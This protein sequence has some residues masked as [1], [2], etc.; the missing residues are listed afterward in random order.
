MKMEKK[1]LNMHFILVMKQR[2]FRFEV[3][4]ENYFSKNPTIFRARA[5]RT[6]INYSSSLRDS[7]KD[8]LSI[9]M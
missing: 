6:L 8:F 7:G 4:Y 9:I 3:I 2:I 5:T 1:H